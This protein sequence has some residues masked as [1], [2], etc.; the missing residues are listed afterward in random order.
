MSKKAEL[1]S[2]CFYFHKFPERRFEPN[3][4]VHHRKG[5]TFFVESLVEFPGVIRAKL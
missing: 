3:K 5:A 1:C 4:A 2:E